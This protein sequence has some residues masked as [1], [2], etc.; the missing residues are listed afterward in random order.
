MAEVKQAEQRITISR[1]RRNIKLREKLQLIRGK[2]QR[3]YI[4]HFRKE[5]VVER[6]SIR[7]GTCKRCGACCRLLFRC[8]YA[9]Q[10]HGGGVSCRIYSRRPVNCRIFPLDREH[11]AERDLMMPDRSCG[12]YFED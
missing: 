7:K 5:Y 1:R 9:D 8:V 6:L 10:C 3:F 2:L 4:G 12:Y 11:L